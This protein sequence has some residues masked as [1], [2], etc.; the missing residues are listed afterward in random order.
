MSRSLY[1]R[2][3]AGHLLVIL[4]V[5]CQF[6]LLHRHGILINN[7]HNFKL[8]KLNLCIVNNNIPT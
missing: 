6:Y 1:L 5:F 7:K 2:D 4:L 8:S 3:Y